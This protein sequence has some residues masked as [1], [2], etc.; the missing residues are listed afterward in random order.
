MK[1]VIEA[2]IRQKQ[3]GVIDTQSGDLDYGKGV[4]PWVAWGPYPWADGLNPRSDGLIWERADF[5]GDGTH[6]SQSGE[7][8]VGTLLL[9]F[10]KSSPQTRCWFLRGLTCP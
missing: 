7:D 1:W 10:F 6:P 3:N 8:K 4:A 9:D 5:G 2:Q